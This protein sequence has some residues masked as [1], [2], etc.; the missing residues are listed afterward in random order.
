MH[1]SVFDTKYQV[2]SLDSKIVAALERLSDVFR[3][4]LAEEYKQHNLTILEVRVLMFVCF[5]NKEDC[6]ISR[7]TAELK[8]PQE[9]TEHIIETLKTKKI[10]NQETNTENYYSV[11]PKGKIL[12]HKVSLFANQIAGQVSSME[13]T[14]QEVL[15]ESILELIN[16]L[17]Q[18][19]MI[20]LVKM[21]L[22]CT[23]YQTSSTNPT[24]HFCKFIG[25][26]LKTRELRLNCADH[27]LST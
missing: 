26:E 6:S 27:N 25:S 3:T 23:N 20:P 15:L 2:T 16:K 8:L 14:K 18:S 7:I 19:G 10:I 22:N 13:V 24:K 4:G 12:V 9:T 21:C 11:T 1:T 5:N 17:Q